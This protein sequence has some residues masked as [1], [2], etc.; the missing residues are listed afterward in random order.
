MS[1]M[2]FQ[3]TGHST[4]GLKFVQ[5]KKNKFV[6]APSYASLSYSLR[7][8]CGDRRP[9]IPKSVRRSHG[10]HP[11]R[12]ATSEFLLATR[13]W[14]ALQCFNLTLIFWWKRNAT[15]P[16]PRRKQHRKVTIRW[17]DC[18]ATTPQP[19]RKR[20]NHPANSIAKSQCHGWVTV[21]TNRSYHQPRW[22][23][24]K[25]VRPNYR[26][27]QENLT[28]RCAHM[29]LTCR[30]HITLCISAMTMCFSSAGSENLYLEIF[31]KL[32]VTVKPCWS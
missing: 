31:R 21:T 5:E 11:S 13:L 17:S 30:C 10:F 25:T 16:Q 24:P 23:R 15:T 18:A 7:R 2:A 27:Y 32:V 19:R 29:T 22:R 8:V 20:H 14:Q 4:V 28:V 12:V 6:K 26:G 1:G 9:L 3:I